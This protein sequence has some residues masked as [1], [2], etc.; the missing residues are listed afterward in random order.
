MINSA[1]SNGHAIATDRLS[2][3]FGSKAAVDE[4]SL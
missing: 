3:R 1:P 4:L 2:K